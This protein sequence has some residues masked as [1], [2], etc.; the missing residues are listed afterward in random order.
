[1][2]A[3]AIGDSDASPLRH[4]ALIALLLLTHSGLLLWQGTW[5]APNIDES[6][7]L[8]SGL[9]HLLTGDFT[10][11]RV[12]PP[13]IRT[14]AALPLLIVQ[15]KTD[16][17]FSET[18]FGRPEFSIGRRF[19]E[20]NGPTTFWHFTLARW[21]LVPIS[22]IG[23]IVCYCWATD[24]YGPAAGI[25]SLTMWTFCPNLL[26]WGA[27]I[28]PDAGAAAFGVLASWRYWHWLRCPSRRQVVLAGV[29]LGVAELTKST[30]I[31]LFALWPLLW[32]A[33]RL[34]RKRDTPNRHSRPTF[35]QLTAILLLGVYLLNLGYGFE[36]TG[37][38]LKEFTFISGALGDEQGGNRFRG[39]WL[40]EVPIPLPRNYVSGLDLQRSDFEQGKV[41]YLRGE[42]RKGGWW[43]YYLYGFLVKS[44]VGY[45][46]LFMLAGALV[47]HRRFR[48][49]HE[50]ELLLI[51]P[52][53]AL[54]LVVSSQ[55]GFNRHL[56]YALPAMP[57]LYISI[58]RS[59]ILF[60]QGRN[61]GSMMVALLITLGIAS[62][63][64][65]APF[66]HS[67]FNLAVGGPNSGRFHLLDSN[68]DWGQDLRRLVRWQ[69]RNPNSRPLSVLLTTPVPLGSLKADM[70]RFRFREGSPA[71]PGWYAIGVNQLMGYP[72]DP[73]RTRVAEFLDLKPIDQIGYSIMIFR[74]K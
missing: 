48:S 67:Y 21:A 59:A 68:V 5:N 72:E 61:I 17:H 64:S 32:L 44:P 45:L 66:F 57:F 24:L 25:L 50:N 58:S 51:L 54:I 52:S 41:S 33:W 73:L 30:W 56:R 3:K 35:R 22:L 71:P 9:S 47:F 29:S 23:A 46:G 39:T 28:T 4:R 42:R 69:E 19:H 16:W 7:H 63:L 74:I 20:I 43:D 14:W 65:V 37:T 70:H 31:I 1:M 40:A 15:P 11:Y 18:P 12:N 60:R 10:L 34:F 26:C 49:S 2:R 13:L 55:M 6:A 38:R 53:L 36:D 27:S 8:P 62:S